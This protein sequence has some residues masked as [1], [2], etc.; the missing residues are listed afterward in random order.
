MTVLGDGEPKTGLI[1]NT[2][3]SGFIAMVGLL[4]TK[5]DSRKEKNELLF[6]VLS[7]VPCATTQLLRPT[8]E[9]RE[10]E[11]FM[12]VGVGFCQIY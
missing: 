2:T 5:N 12:A 6:K 3:T 10:R 1:S 9:R 7:L 11:Y 4:L 8:L